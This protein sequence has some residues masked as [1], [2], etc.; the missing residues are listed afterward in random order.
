LCTIERSKESYK[1][2]ERMMEGVT[3]K[4]KRKNE[5]IGGNMKMSPK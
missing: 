3:T 1:K 5:E 2:T 4:E